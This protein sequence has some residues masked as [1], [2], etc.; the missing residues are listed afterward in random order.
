MALGV[1]LCEREGVGKGRDMYIYVGIYIFI[2]AKYA[3]LEWSTMPL[4]C[5]FF[6]CQTQDASLCFL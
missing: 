1:K 6:V 3:K 4:D 5:Y 2:Y